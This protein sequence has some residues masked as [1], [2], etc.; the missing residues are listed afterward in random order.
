MYVLISELGDKRGEVTKVDKELEEKEELAELGRSL[1]DSKIEVTPE[2]SK[3]V[4]E[5]VF[6]AGGYGWS[7]NYTKVLYV[8]KPHLYV[9]K[10]GGLAYSDAV[11]KNF[12]SN[13]KK[14]VKVSTKTQLVVEDVVQD[15][16]EMLEELS[17]VQKELEEVNKRIEK[18][19]SKLNTNQ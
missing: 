17:N 10:V 1:F 5:A 19:K 7:G 12:Q 2:T 4:Q 3:L 6:V 14:E 13:P 18:I 16:S 9:S 15:K 8:D 11:D